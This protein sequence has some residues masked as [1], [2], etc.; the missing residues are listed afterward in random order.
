MSLLPNG[1]GIYA[2]VNG[3]TAVAGVRL[4]VWEKGN[5]CDI[6][7]GNMHLEGLLEMYPLSQ[8]GR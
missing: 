6:S 8:Q 3:L 7:F 1:R 4:P 5:F 2:V